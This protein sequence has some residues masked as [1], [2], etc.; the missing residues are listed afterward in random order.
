VL[1]ALGDLL[2]RLPSLLEAHY[3]NADMVTDGEG[4]TVRTGLRMLDYQ[5]AG[6]VF[7]TQ[8]F[9][10]PNFMC[11]ILFG[12]ICIHFLL[13]NFMCFI[14][15]GRIYIHF[16]FRLL[17]MVEDCLDTEFCLQVLMTLKFLNLFLNL[18]LHLLFNY[19]K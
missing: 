8:V 19:S 14:L 1:P 15:F 3:E 9:L 17:L 13:P 11:F 2:L 10:L 5:E 7:L 6:A 18:C 16:F 4:A 12:R